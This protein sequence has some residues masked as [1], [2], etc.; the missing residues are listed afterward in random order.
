LW[1][2]R[3]RSKS[4]DFD[5]NQRQQEMLRAIF[6]Q[7]LRLEMV[8]QVSGLYTQ[9][10]DSVVTDFTLVDALNLA[11][12]VADLNS[13]QVR[14]YYIG[15]NILSRW[16]TPRGRE[17]QIPNRQALYALMAEA[18]GPPDEN[19]Q[20]HTQLTVEIWNGTSKPG[21]GTL[22]AERLNYAGF[23][24]QINP[25]DNTSHAQ[26]TLFD[27]TTGDDP[28]ATQTLGALFNL[29]PNLITSAPNE[30]SP[31]DFLLILGADF[32]PCFSPLEI[33]R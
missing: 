14:S 29:D 2:V 22:A 11:P 25:P 15:R 17:V 27:Y 32:D 13:A 6:S 9:L 1:Y 5:R 28:E 10:S 18:L 23:H 12:F 19:E 31:V 21:W 20:R 26:T 33:H 3:A 24:S 4:S 30:D 16:K 7:A 8:T